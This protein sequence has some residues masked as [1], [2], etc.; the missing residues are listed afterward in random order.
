MAADLTGLPGLPTGRPVSELAAEMEARHFPVREFQGASSRQLTAEEIRWAWWWTTYVLG[1]ARR[2]LGPLLVT[3]YE[4]NTHPHHGGPEL[5]GHS[6]ENA[7][8]YA[9]DVVPLAEGVTVRQLR[10]WLATHRIEYLGEL[11]DERDHVH[12]TVRGVGGW[13]EVWN[14]PTEGTY[15][16]GR[17][18][19]AVLVGLLALMAVGLLALGGVGG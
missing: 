17:V 4:R 15:E 7:G 10:D 6:T 14:E 9:L 8:G 11:I 2:Q 3:S 18:L 12:M 5:G 19:P 13:G 16:P 1:P